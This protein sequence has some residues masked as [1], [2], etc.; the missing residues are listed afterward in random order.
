MTV[1]YDGVILGGTIQA[2]LMA[3]R[4]ARQGARIALVEAP[5]SV[6]R[7]QRRQM[8]IAVLARA[9]AARQSQWFP[10]P[11]RPL[12]SSDWASL[13]QRVALAVE[14]ADGQTSLHDLA[15]AGVDIVPEVGQ[16]APK[17]RLAITTESRRLTGRS[18]LLSPPV[19]V[20]KPAILGLSEAPVLIPETLLD[21]SAPPTELAILGR[22]P[23]A[24]ALAQALALL[25]IRTTLISQGER[26]LATEDPDMS[27]FVESLLVAAGV[28]LRLQVRLQGIQ[29]QDKVAI[30]FTDGSVLKVSHLLVATSLQPQLHA[31]NLGQINLQASPRAIAVDDL[32]K[33][34]HPRCFAFGPCLGGYWSDHRDH[35]DGPV[36]LQNALYFPW[37][38]VHQLNRVCRLTTSPEFARFGLTA[39]QALRYYGPAAQVIQIPF[40]QISKFHL[41]DRMTGICRCIIHQNGMVLGAQIVADNGTDLV[42]TLAL[43]AHQHV[44][45]QALDRARTVSITDLEM[46]EQ[47]SEAWQRHR[48]QPGCWR[49]DWAENWFNWRRTRL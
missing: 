11:P 7:Q 8:T 29:H 3:T 28:D 32:L 31:L 18:Y 5:M 47:I 30:Q 36:A 17:P 1:N 12:D 38:K 39:Q 48:W 34:S 27:Q 22:S 26:L 25:G 43:M 40:E 44:P 41:D 23:D 46:L 2:R 33:T 4:A 10:A 15:V 14:M 21:L 20:M 49:R 19:E 9:G 42:Q 16:F 6:N 24:I 13:R 45:I 35:Q 37:R